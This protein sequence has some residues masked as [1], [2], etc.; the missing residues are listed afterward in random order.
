MRGLEASEVERWRRRG[1]TEVGAGGWGVNQA[2]TSEHFPSH[3]CPTLLQIPAPAPSPRT[4]T[5]TAAGE[6]YGGGGVMHCYIFTAYALVLAVM[7]K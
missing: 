3:P 7:L 4:P 5:A 6:S 1:A 2:H